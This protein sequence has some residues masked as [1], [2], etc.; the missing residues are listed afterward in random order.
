MV[1][2]GNKSRE[3]RTIY[4]EDGS[5]QFLMRGQTIETS[6]KVKRIQEG[7]VIIE[8]Q[9]AS[10]KRTSNKANTSDE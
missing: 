7:I 9:K 8:S 2:Y 4:F 10:P 5:A 3:M 6:K 1:K